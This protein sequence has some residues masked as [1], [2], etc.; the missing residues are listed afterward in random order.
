[1]DENPNPQSEGEAQGSSVPPISPASYPNEPPPAGETQEA[2]TWN[3]VCHL[4]ALAGVT[5]IPFAHNLGPSIGWRVKKDPVSYIYI[6]L[7]TTL[8]VYI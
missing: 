2:R 4:A 5:S 8:H 7:H 3:M 6:T 1:M